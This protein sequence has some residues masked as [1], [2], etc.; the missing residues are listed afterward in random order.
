ML[1]HVK[2]GTKLF[3]GFVLVLIL[4]AGTAGIGYVALRVNQQATDEMLVDEELYAEMRHYSQLIYKAKFCAA[5]AS[6]FRDLGQEAARQEVDVEI[7]EIEDKVIPLLKG[8]D[9]TLFAEVVELYKQY[10]AEDF[11]WF[12]AEEKRAAGLEVITKNGETITADLT[13]G[14]NIFTQEMLVTKAGEG[15]EATVQYALAKQVIDLEETIAQMYRLRRNCFRLMAEPD[16]VK[17]QEIIGI[18]ETEIEQQENRFGDIQ[19]GIIPSEHQQSI[20]D[21]IRL[22]KEWFVALREN[23]ELLNEQKRIDTLHDEQSDKISENL[24]LLMK[25]LLKH[26]DEIRERSAATTAWMIRVMIG[27]SIIAVILGLVISIVLARNITKGIG[28]VVEEIGLIADEGDVSVVIPDSEKKRGDEVGALFCAIEH[29]LHQFQNVERLADNLAA[30]NYNIETTV[31]GNKDTMNVNLNKMLEQVNAAMREINECVVQVATGSTEVATA[32]NNL[33]DGATT[34]AASL[35]EIS[36]S[37]HEISSQTKA[38]AEG[39]TQARNLISQ[40]SQVASEGQ[41][42]M[43]G[44][45]ESMHRI[46]QNSTEIQ[47]VIKV[48]DDIA[49]QT[50]LLA[51]NAA[52]EAAR[53]GQ[54]GKGFAVVAEEVRNLASRSAKAAQ[55]TADLISKSSS[56]IEKGAVIAASTAT[57]FDTIAGQIKQTTDLVAGIATASNEQAQGV[58]HITAGLQQVD[59]VMQQNTASAEESASAANEISSMA[60]VLRKRVAQFKLRV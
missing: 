39:A 59:A 11:K 30:G 28:L 15:N 27:T 31:R 54:H 36:A 32:A 20:N 49:F 48:V 41:A 21:A 8:N 29:V 10:I 5:K 33:A 4:L 18:I 9:A 43:H 37:M 55:E 26:L 52:V 53:A 24:Y 1:N 19:R 34:T 13:R 17:S 56:E 35:Q 23:I 22:A 2:I 3:L 16:F 58:N 60:D 38:N 51:L 57:V 47:R 6:L 44:M 42:A 50:N 7:K 45:D 46:T 12:R 14:L 25:S 40:V